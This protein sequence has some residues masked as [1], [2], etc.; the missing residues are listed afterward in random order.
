MAPDSFTTRWLRLAALSELFLGVVILGVFATW[1]RVRATSRFTSF[2]LLAPTYQSVCSD[3]KG[4]QQNATA[5][6]SWTITPLSS[7]SSGS[8]FVDL[9]GR[10]ST[11]IQR[12]ESVLPAAIRG[13]DL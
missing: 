11:F 2:S 6:S 1:R 9:A 12:L 8:I 3:Q 13:E 5:K 7:T 10:H 4:M